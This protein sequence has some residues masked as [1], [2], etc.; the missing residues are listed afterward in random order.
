MIEISQYRGRDIGPEGPG[1]RVLEQPISLP[2]DDIEKISIITPENPAAITL[3][4]H[5]LRMYTC[6][7]KI[8]GYL[9]DSRV[10]QGQTGKISGYLPCSSLFDTRTG[11]IF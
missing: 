1:F 3:L 9:P 8:S 11:K 10:K 4:S 2:R 6:N 5:M 7:E